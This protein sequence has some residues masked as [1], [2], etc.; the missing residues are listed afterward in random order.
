MTGKAANNFPGFQGFPG[1]STTQQNSMY[2]SVFQPVFFTFKHTREGSPEIYLDT[3]DSLTRP[4]D[5]LLGPRL[6][7]QTNDD[8]N[9]GP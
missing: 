5:T 1:Q 7:I 3:L 8:L 6:L 9:L 4:M 2:S